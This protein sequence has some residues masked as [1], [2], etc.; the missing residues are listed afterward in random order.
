V[1]TRIVPRPRAASGFAVPALYDRCEAEGIAYTLRVATNVRL[2]DL[3]APL[4]EQAARQ[5]ELTG[6]KGR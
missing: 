6:K 4:S 2:Q 3:V 5:H 1:L